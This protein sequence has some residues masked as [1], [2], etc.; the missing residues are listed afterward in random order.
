MPKNCAGGNTG[1][2]VNG[3]ELCDK[4]LDLLAGRGFS[5]ATGSYILDISGRVWDEF[6]G[7]ELDSIGKL[8]PT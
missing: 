8:A 2:L 5:T 4:D 6:S 1:I 7:E 3:R